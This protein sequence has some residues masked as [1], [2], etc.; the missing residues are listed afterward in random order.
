M[1]I[2]LLI[3]ED[4]PRSTA[5]LLRSLGYDA[6]D[7]RDIGLRG[8]RDDEIFAYAYKADA[9]IVTGDVGFVG[10]VY[11]SSQ[12]HAGIILLRLPIDISIQGVNEILLKAISVLS[13]DQIRGNII[14]VDQQKV[15]IRVGK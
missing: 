1:S 8:A 10:M 3:D 4:P 7:V 2:G 15:R 9:T 5:P 11:R 14:V 13:E 12:A 6:L